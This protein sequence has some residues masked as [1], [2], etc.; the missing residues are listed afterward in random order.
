LRRA[1][2]EPELVEAVQVGAAHL[3]AVLAEGL[4]GRAGRD[5]GGR[6]RVEQ[7]VR[8]ELAVLADLEA[9]VDHRLGH[10]GRPLLVIGAAQRHHAVL[11]GGRPRGGQRE[12]RGGGREPGTDRA[13]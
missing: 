7:R 6:D 12:Q 8:V 11:G 2:A 13:G 5:R 3:D 1:A 9:R 10:A 4:V